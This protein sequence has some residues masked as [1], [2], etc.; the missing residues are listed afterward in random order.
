MTEAALAVDR[1]VEGRCGSLQ[2][3][4][5]VHGDWSF[6]GSYVVL[7]VAV[8]A[9]GGAAVIAAA[10][11][12]AEPVAV[13]AGTSDLEWRVIVQMRVAVAIEGFHRSLPNCL[14]SEVS[15]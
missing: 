5:F 15:L 12:V 2:A 14:P 11:A 1:R 3:A 4:R 9:P 8:F 7:A 13:A 6:A 10:V